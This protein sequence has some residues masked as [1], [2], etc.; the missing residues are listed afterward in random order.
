MDSLHKKMKHLLF[1]LFLLLFIANESAYGIHPTVRNFNR[2]VSNAG[3]QNWDIVQHKNDWMYFANNKG[4]MEFDGNRW[5]IYPISNYT[6][7]RSLY[8]DD[9]SDRIYAG[10]F[11]E[12]GFYK[13]DKVGLLHYTSLIEKI[14]PKERSFNEVWNIHKIES[15]FY[16]QGDNEI[17]RYKDDKIFKFS[18]RNKIDCSGV[19]HNSLFIAHKRRS[20]FLKWKPVYE[21][22]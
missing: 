18:F 9:A 13:R 17:F 16:F 15:S 2:K 21:N 8:Y 12:F 4:L 20:L 10:A 11:N 19:V 5:T 22:S 6:N 1:C 14:D 3:T 7:V